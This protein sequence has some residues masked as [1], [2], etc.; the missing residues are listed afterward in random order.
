MNAVAAMLFGFVHGNVCRIQN[1]LQFDAVGIS[2]GHAQAGGQ[3]D[4]PL[5]M[6]KRVTGDVAAQGFRQPWQ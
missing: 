1:L 3:M 4:V 2:F 6:R 5:I